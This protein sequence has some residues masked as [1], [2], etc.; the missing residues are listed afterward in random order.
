MTLG[1]IIKNRQASS[2]LRTI[3]HRDMSV[4]QELTNNSRNMHESLKC[5]E[6][7]E[8]LSQQNLVLIYDESECL[9]FGPRKARLALP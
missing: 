1:D 9:C 3:N 2:Q 6:C 5:S 4:K 8:S 7:S